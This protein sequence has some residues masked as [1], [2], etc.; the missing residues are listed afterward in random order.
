[1]FVRRGSKRASRIIDSSK[2][3]TSIMF[4]VS[5]DGVMLPPYVVYKAT[6]L[7]PEWIQNGPD[8]TMYNRSASGWFDS[9]LFEEW[10]VK[11]ALPFLKRKEG[12][13]VL[14]GDNLSSHISV[15]IINKCEENNILFLLLPPNSTHLCQPL[16]VPIFRPMKI[17]WRK[18][19]TSWKLKHRGTVPKSTFP[20]LLKQLLI[21]VGPKL[22][23]NIKSG[24]A[25]SGIIPFDLQRV[26][27]KVLGRPA[28][29]VHNNALT[30]SFSEILTDKIGKDEKRT[31]TRKK[32]I[33][34]E[35]GQSVKGSQFQNNDNTPENVS[36]DNAAIDIEIQECEENSSS[37]E[38]EPSVP[39]KRQ[40]NIKKVPKKCDIF[41]NSFVLVKF[42]YN[43]GTKKETE[44][45]FVA[46]VLEI[47][48]SENNF[49][50]DCLR[51]FQGK[52]DQFV[53]PNM[54]DIC[55]ISF[56][57]I[58]FILENPVICRGKHIFDSEI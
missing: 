13:K 49:K 2:S 34:V 19:L 38:S 11:I 31:I 5:G 45:K 1:M 3:S 52:K 44:K 54:R 58:E 30:Q 48:K 12:V 53:F 18:I 42:V 51:N 6:N 29:N 25:A 28:N 21:M 36:N 14:I 32:K 50:V 17:A 56:E 4:A 47:N 20:S 57:Q 55:V 24:F 46:Q 9:L 37:D 33:N 26:L 40:R 10:F 39:P 35:A 7:Y 27:N 16:D 15:N 22:S 8:G 41:R 23:T 43:Q